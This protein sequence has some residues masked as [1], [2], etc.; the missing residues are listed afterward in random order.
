[1]TNFEIFD[2][3]SAPLASRDALHA[4]AKKAGFIPRIFGLFATSHVAIHALVALSA[5]FQVTAF[6]AREREVISMAT[7]AENQC[8]YCVAGHTAFAHS[9]GFSDDDLHAM[10]E[11]EKL[12]DPRED[13][14]YRFAREVVTTR[15]D[16]SP[17][18]LKYFFAAGFNTRHVFD[19]MIGVAEKTM[20]NFASKIAQLKLDKQFA[21]FAWTPSNVSAHFPANAA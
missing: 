8:A 6:T 14:L 9:T 20:T 12:G 7:S 21:E 11:G 10:R 19:L 5:A 2:E 4:I 17:S 1:M 16:I 13:A 15:G 18:A 3:K